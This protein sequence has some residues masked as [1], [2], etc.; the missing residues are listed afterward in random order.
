M[1][2]INL[3]K[4]M[5]DRKKLLKTQKNNLKFL[6]QNCKIK[7]FITNNWKESCKT[8]R[9]VKT[10]LRAN[11]WSSFRKIR[12]WKKSLIT[13]KMNRKYR[14]LKR[15]LP[16]KKKKNRKNRNTKFRSMLLICWIRLKMKCIVKKKLK[17]NS[18][19]RLKLPLNR[20]IQKKIYQNLTMQMMTN[21][22]TTSKKIK[23]IVIMKKRRKKKRNVEMRLWIMYKDRF[24]MI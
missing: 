24:R 9:R 15:N 1:L 3:Q 2:L 20:P 17:R 10:T 11:F 6:T 8:L 5:I 7:V 21:L 13:R 14:K 16:R 23:I 19:V 4:R 22:K 18:I 12:P